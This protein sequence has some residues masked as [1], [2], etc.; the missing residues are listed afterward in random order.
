MRLPTPPCLEGPALPHPNHNVNLFVSAEHPQLITNANEFESL[1]MSC[2]DV[3][4]DG[5]NTIKRVDVAGIHTVVKSYKIPNRLQGFIYQYLRRSKARRSY[6]YAEKLL[7]KG[8]NT[9]APLAYIET[10]NKLQL[11]KSYF[12]SESLDYDFEIR[13]VLNN[14]TAD[15]KFLLEEFAR[16]THRLHKNGILHLDYS[17]GNIL[18][19]KIS[20]G[21]YQFSVVDINRMRFAPVSAQEGINNFNRISAE[22]ENMA[23]FSNVYAPLVGMTVEV[24]E[25]LM[26]QSVADYQNQRE[27]KRRF[28]KML[29]LG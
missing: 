22:P 24:C 27:R 18:I 15:K 4:Q 12:V 10:F 9:P 19:K 29:G 21:D 14:K 20:E 7:A 23:I 28:K 6:E 25:Q 26:Q 17:T 3:I 1:F 2:C 8:I 11:L 16:F 13:D 5:R